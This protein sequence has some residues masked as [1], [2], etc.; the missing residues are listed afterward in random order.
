MRH[1]YIR[2]PATT[3]S[4]LDRRRDPIHRYIHNLIQS[5]FDNEALSEAATAHHELLTIDA[6]SILWEELYQLVYRSGQ[7]CP[8]HK[9]VADR[10]RLSE[11]SL[12]VFTLPIGHCP[13]GT[14]LSTR[15]TISP[16]FKLSF[17]RDQAFGR[18]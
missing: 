14:V 13:L 9:I 7:M 8:T 11:L 12:T 15:S 10:T 1:N 5:A 4:P 16:A 18:L 17:F 3:P 6:S 2:S